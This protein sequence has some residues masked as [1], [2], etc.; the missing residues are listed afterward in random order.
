MSGIVAACRSLAGSSRLCLAYFSKGGTQTTAKGQARGP[1]H[2]I[3]PDIIVPGKPTGV[4]VRKDPRQVTPRRWTRVAEALVANLDEWHLI[5]T[6]P[7]VPDK[8]MVKVAQHTVDRLN[9]VGLPDNHYQMIVV[10]RYITKQF[11]MNAFDQ[12]QIESE[13]FRQADGSLEVWARFTQK[14]AA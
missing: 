13:M 8:D 12:W 11:G 7:L 3:D 14:L 10:K 1:N 2:F 5:T 9:R 6:Y 4:Q